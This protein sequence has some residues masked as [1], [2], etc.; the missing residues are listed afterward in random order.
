MFHKNLLRIVLLVLL[1]ALM[2]GVAGA[3]EDV[4]LQFV[5]WQEPYS[6]EFGF[7]APEGWQVDA[8]SYSLFGYTQPYV[9]MMEP[10]ERAAVIAGVSAPQ[11]F[12]EPNA[13]LGLYTG[14]S[15]ELEG[16]TV[17][18]AEYQSPV[19]FLYGY[20]N[21]FLVPAVCENF[22]VQET[23]PWE[24]VEVGTEE[25]D[26][27]LTCTYPEGEAFGYFYAAM[28][29]VENP[30]FGT[31]WMLGDFSGY[32]AEAGYEAQADAALVRLVE[33]FSYNQESI[34]Q[35]D[36]SI[37]QTEDPD[38]YQQMMQD[39]QTTAMISNMLSMQ[40]QTNM[41]IINN[42]GGGSGGWTYEYQYQYVPVYP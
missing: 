6:N 35:P 32:L 30:D 26:L 36:T 21:D 34:P 28:Y 12:A 23:R 16:V 27:I 22:T 5:T 13:A 4:Q 15:F 42:I 40:H 3:Q 10:G 14:D 38:A 33:T 9:V 8:T 7:E 41:A 11:V 25:G 1:L 18:V 31:I 39:Y 29:R 24:V 17:T 2:A 19:D 37:T 20:L